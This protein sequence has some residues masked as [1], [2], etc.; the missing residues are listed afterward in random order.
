MA[1]NSWL[2]IHENRTEY[3]WHGKTVDRYCAVISQQFRTYMRMR[4]K[5]WRTS[6]IKRREIKADP[7]TDVSQKQR[8]LAKCGSILEIL[9]PRDSSV[10]N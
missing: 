6:K 5:Y 7:M 1:R 2:N 8:R 4:Q 10:S 9:S 3:I